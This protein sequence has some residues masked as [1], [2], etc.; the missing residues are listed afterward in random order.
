MLYEVVVLSY[1]LTNVWLFVNSYSKIS[2]TCLLKHKVDSSYL[3][4]ITAKKIVSVE[5]IEKIS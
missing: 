4:E 2:L 1:F 3:N 5:H